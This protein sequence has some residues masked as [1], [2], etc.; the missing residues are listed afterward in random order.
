LPDTGIPGNLCS[1]VAEDLELLSERMA[2]ED[3]YKY[4]VEFNSQLTHLKSRVRDA[5][6]TISD[7]QKLRLKEGIEDLQRLPAWEELTQEERGNAVDRLDDLALSASQDLAGLK[8]LLA[9][10]YDINIIIEDLKRSIQR[11]GHDRQRQRQEEERAKTGEKGP[12]K[13]SKSIFV[14]LKMTTSADLDTLI[15]QLHEIKA[16]WDLYSE[17]EVTFAIKGNP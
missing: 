4:T 10:D 5:V 8:K 13:L 17:I 9:R 14:P 1:E 3:F 6:I 11:Q 15:R 7:H 2:R 12:M 16:K